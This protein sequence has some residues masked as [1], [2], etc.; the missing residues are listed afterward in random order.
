M[1]SYPIILLFLLSL[2]VFSCTD[3]LTDIGSGVQ[4]IS[5]QIKVG[6]DTFHL[7]TTTDPVDYI[8]SRPDSFL[9]GSFYDTKF[10]S[11]KADILA[12]LNCPVGF[13]YPSNAVPDSAV[14]LMYYKTWVG[15]KYSPLDIN[16]YQMNMHNTFDY[17]KLYHSDLNPSD[18]CDKSIKLGQKIF[19]AKDAVIIRADSTAIRF[20]LSNS[21]VSKFGNDAYYS[22][23]NNFLKFFN[24]IYITANYG[25]STMLT[26]EQIDLRYYYH[27]TYATKNING[28]DSI[29]TVNDVR[30]FPANSEV[31][32]VN[33][34]VHDRSTVDLNRDTVNYIASPANLQTRINVPLNRIKQRMD[35]GTKGKNLSVNSALLRV[36]ITEQTEDT[37]AKR[38]APTYLLLIKESAKRRFF[39]NRELPSDTC[40][41]Q[42]SYT[43]EQIGTTGVYKHY[44]SFNMST[45]VANEFKIAKQNGTTLPESMNML[46]VPI[47]VSTTTN[48]SGV[49]SY[50]YV[51]E[52]HL[53]NSVTIR[54]GKVI[55]PNGKDK[56]KIT[57][58]MMIKV[59]YSG[60]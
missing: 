58:P 57:A 8:N 39:D 37:T 7:A 11:T 30:T 21:F 12:Q 41:I 25:A 35:A 14:V 26:I 1:K 32:Q 40:A 10:G 55:D 56:D 2:F 20:K 5:D 4:P 47:K 49:T 18:Y 46:L 9:L 3:S 17:T 29:A 15:S 13:K 42:G 6:T 28:G 24:G 36:E 54:S 22:S 33:H 45:L 60:F 27:Y 51:K 31:R 19:S 16:I 48:S 44:Y 50:I 53:M 43:T 59:V 34:F 38:T 52:S 23:I